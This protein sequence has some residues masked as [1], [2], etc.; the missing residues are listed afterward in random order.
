MSASFRSAVE[1]AERAKDG[2]AKFLQD[3]SDAEVKKSASI[4]AAGF[5]K[6]SALQDK[7]RKLDHPRI[8]YYDE[9]R[10]PIK[11]YSIPHMKELTALEEYFSK[12]ND[13]FEAACKKQDYEKLINWTESQEPKGKE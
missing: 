9:N 10:K 12:G 3:E 4:I 5:K 11:N 13:A 7:I 1:P 8:A 6:L 2:I